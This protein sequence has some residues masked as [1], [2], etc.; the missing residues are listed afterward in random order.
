M[1][2]CSKTYSD[3]PFAHRQ[4][5]HDGHCRLIHGHNWEFTFTFA[6]RERDE[7]GFVYD[8]GKL[9]WLKKYLEQYDHALLLNS[10][11]PK[12]EFLQKVLDGTFARILVVSDASSEGLAVSLFESVTRMLENDDA[13][14]RGI[15]IHRVEVMEDSKNGATYEE[16]FVQNRQSLLGV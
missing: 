7:N 15:R 1:F 9:K 10:R 16:P 11:D 2:T 3:I 6:A 13:K 8:F 14:A 4:H 5:N 12:L